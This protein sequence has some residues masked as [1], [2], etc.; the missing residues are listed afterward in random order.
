MNIHQN[1][2]LIFASFFKIL[3]QNGSNAICSFL[4]QIVTFYKVLIFHK[5]KKTNYPTICI[6]V[7]S[8]TFCKH[9]WKYALVWTKSFMIK[10]FFFKHH[11]DSRFWMAINIKRWPLVYVLPQMVNLIPRSFQKKNSIKLLYKV[12]IIFSYIEKWI[13]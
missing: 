4:A 10:L 12:A 1:L 3:F 9:D 6:Y 2:F 7:L 5:G 13:A 11:G 8:C